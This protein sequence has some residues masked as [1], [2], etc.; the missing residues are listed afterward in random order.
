MKA[1]RQLRPGTGLAALAIGLLVSACDTGP[2]ILTGIGEPIRISGG[3]F[4]EG[5]LPGLPPGSDAGA[6]SQDGGAPPL[7]VTGVTFNSTLILP[8]QSGKSFGGDVTN[9]AVAVG[10]ALQGLG[11]G[12]W[13]VP[14]GAPDPGVPDSVIFNL[15]A[16]FDLGDPPGIRNLLIVAIGPSGQGGLQS[17]T[18]LCF[19]SRIPDNGHACMPSSAPP[20]TVFTLQWDTSFDLDLQVRAPNGQ[21]FTPRLPYGEALDAGERTIPPGMPH[22]DRDSDG[23]CVADGLNQEDL[24]FDDPPPAGRYTVYVDPYSACG[25]QTARFKFTLYQVQGTC[26]ACTQVAITSVSGE[27]LASQETGGSLVP[28][29]IAQVNL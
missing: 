3:Q 14:T 27:V 10:T 7:S 29:Q 22:I 21:V 13:I 1:L 9:D 28:L 6:S 24:I 11:T 19:Q 18:P 5:S 25:Q 15:P 17:P 16:N 20:N 26:P 8:G 2:G 4:V 23:N 12:Y